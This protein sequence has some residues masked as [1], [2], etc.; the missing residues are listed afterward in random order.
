MSQ[1][2]KGTHAHVERAR[3]TLVLAEEAYL[4]ANGWER[5]QVAGDWLWRKNE[6]TPAGSTVTMR[7]TDAVWFQA[8]KLGDKK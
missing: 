3:Q 1:P 8:I 7:R 2:R 5:A 6:C 4:A